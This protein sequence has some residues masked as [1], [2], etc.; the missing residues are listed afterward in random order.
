MT[1]IS[2]LIY[3]LFGFSPLSQEQN[4]SVKQGLAIF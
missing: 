1:A 2:L 4:L 3:A